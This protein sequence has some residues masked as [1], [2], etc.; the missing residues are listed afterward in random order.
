MNFTIIILFIFFRSLL[1]CVVAGD[2]KTVVPSACHHRQLVMLHNNKE[3]MGNPLRKHTKIRMVCASVNVRWSRRKTDSFEIICKHLD[4]RSERYKYEF[5]LLDRTSANKSNEYEFMQHT[6]KKAHNSGTMM[7][8][9]KKSQFKHFHRQYS[10]AR[11]Q[12]YALPNI[13]V[14]R[15][16]FLLFFSCH[17]NKNRILPLLYSIPFPLLI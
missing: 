4:W 9:Q 11:V 17:C 14:C 12:V 5:G 2:R 8:K 1:L 13:G 3:P 15:F 10:H 6:T 16:W 7:K